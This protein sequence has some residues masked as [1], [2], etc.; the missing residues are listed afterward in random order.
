MQ[1]LRLLKPLSLISI[2]IPH[3]SVQLKMHYDEATIHVVET[4]RSVEYD[5]TAPPK[6]KMERFGDN[7]WYAII[8]DSN[9]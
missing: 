1:L 9:P 5:G 7:L 8:L 6:E 2:G 4:G 3:C